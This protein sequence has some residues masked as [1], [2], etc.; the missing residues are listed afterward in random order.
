MQI[1]ERAAHVAPR[2]VLMDRQWSA[3]GTATPARL[4][5]SRA[6]GA[7]TCQS[8][9]AP[10]C[11]LGEMFASSS[12]GFR[13]SSSTTSSPNSSWH[14]NGKCTCCSTCSL[15]AAE[16]LGAQYTPSTHVC[17]T[18]YLPDERLDH[19]VVDSG[20]Q[21]V[22]IHVRTGHELPEFLQAPGKP[23]PNSSA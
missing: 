7:F 19:Q 17:T 3:S 18:P 22:H 13:P 12:Q 8:S 20:P 16:Q 1:G 2:R 9:S 15:T 14:T 11:R 5:V 10:V 21:F 6:S 23:F 4:S